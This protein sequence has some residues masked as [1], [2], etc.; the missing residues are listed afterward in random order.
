M[1]IW[2]W[3]GTAWLHLPTGTLTTPGTPTVDTYV[4]T[5]TDTY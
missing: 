1:D 3:T 4:D 5:Y 2:A